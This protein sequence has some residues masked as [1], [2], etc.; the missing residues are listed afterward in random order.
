MAYWRETRTRASLE[1]DRSLASRSNHERASERASERVA[2]RTVDMPPHPRPPH[3]PSPRHEGSH[4]MLNAAESN[5]YQQQ[6]R[7]QRRGR[8]GGWDDA[9]DSSSDPE[10]STDLRP[11]QRDP[12]NRTTP[13]PSLTHSN[14][15]PIA[16]PVHAKHLEPSARDVR[17]ED[18]NDRD[19]AP[20]RS[21]SYA[22]ISPP[23]PSSYGP[24][25][26]WT[27]LDRTEITE[28]EKV[29]AAQR[30]ARLRQA[31]SSKSLNAELENNG[32]LRGDSNLGSSR[33]FTNGVAGLSRSFM[34]IALGSPH[35]SSSLR[36]SSVKGKGK[37]V[38]ATLT[39][40]AAHATSRKQAYGR[41]AI[42]SDIDEIL[43]G[44]S[45]HELHWLFT[46]LTRTWLSDPL[47]IL[48]EW[49]SPVPSAGDPRPNAPSPSP[50]VPQPQGADICYSSDAQTA[51]SSRSL[52]RA[53]S[54]RSER[55]RERFAKVLSGK[56]KER[57]ASVDS[58]GS[59]TQ[60]TW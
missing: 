32:S 47:H 15:A 25:A 57:G 14:T 56:A 9:W 21:S 34:N 46:Q 45:P 24:R 58:G 28:A 51:A 48:K 49:A 37:D 8:S 54:L 16:V 10:D 11:G 41:N 50:N 27:I 33:S 19:T 7:Q 60:S 42:R 13:R 20:P 35:S 29:Y 38:A 26:D 39:E 22:H 23:S 2:L 53:R 1:R 3:R 52:G 44:K 4:S 31:T 55:R 40:Q 30:E 59:S 5:G 6:R 18:N 36:N 43:R 12:S 17:G